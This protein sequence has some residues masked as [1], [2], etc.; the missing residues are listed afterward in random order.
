MEKFFKLKERKT[1]VTRE[2]L[3]GIA[4]FFAMA[5][6]IVL[7][8]YTMSQPAAIMGDEQLSS[9]IYNSVF[10]A[11][12]IA[13]FVGT[14]LM[15]VYANLPFAQSTG[16]GLLSMF[17]YSVMLTLDFT[18]QEAL[19][20]VFISGIV[21][22]VITVCGLR[23]AII[24]SIPKNLK[25][26]INGGIGLFIAFIG[27]INAGIVISF[28]ATAVTLQN[29]AVFSS[30]M[31]DSARVEATGALLAIVGLLML[32]VLYKENFKGAILISMAFV[33][34]VGLPLGITEV[35]EAIYT[36]FF[37]TLSTQFRDFI[38]LGVFGFYEGFVSLF[39]DK[40]ILYILGTIVLIVVSFT[41]VDLFDTVGTLIGTAQKANLLKED[42]SMKNMKEALLSDSVAT[43]I[44]AML[45]TATVTTYVE[46]SVGV[47]EGGRTGLTSLVTASLFLLAIPFGPIFSIVPS[48][49]TAPALIFVGSLMMMNLK[50]LDFD[51]I[52]EV[53]PA[54]LTIAL[55]P[56]SYSIANGIAF[57]MIS[58][59]V[60][61][62]CTGKVKEVKPLTIV[63]SAIFVIKYLFVNF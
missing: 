51:S 36:D 2:V 12:C 42:G 61:K 53:V 41:L 22:L 19:A 11:N 43:T 39:L 57:G 31:E 63:L 25:I 37:G 56:L 44:G 16:V 48:V 18:Y 14:G 60:I 47:S 34:L 32:T 7:A 6:I 1:T 33:T 27:L 5:Y 24:V 15:A 30:S 9:Q 55:M 10:F 13:S 17:A 4:T 49:A 21:F 35:P 3:A 8:P 29:L 38:T 54:F 28:E 52:D 46:S 20:V 26:A 45:G 58:Y 59:T 50:D 40:N 23:E 62:L